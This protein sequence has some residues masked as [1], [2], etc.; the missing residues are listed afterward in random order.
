MSNGVKTDSPAGT[1][2]LDMFDFYKYYLQNKF[3]TERKIMDYLAKTHTHQSMLNK[4]FILRLDY[5]SYEK[6]N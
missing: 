5:V 2:T 3:N 1:V 6:Q 4:Y